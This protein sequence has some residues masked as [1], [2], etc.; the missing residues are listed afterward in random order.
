METV[1][2]AHRA[3]TGDSQADICPTCS[4]VGKYPDSHQRAG[5]PCDTCAGAGFL[6]RQRRDSNGNPTRVFIA[7]DSAGGESTADSAATDSTSGASAPAS[8]AAGSKRPT[9]TKS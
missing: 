7:P 2:R 4:G 1:K 5:Q 8:P 9:A 3:D 6:L